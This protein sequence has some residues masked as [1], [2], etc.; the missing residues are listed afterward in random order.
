[1][2]RVLM[3]RFL[4]NLSCGKIAKRL[5]RTTNAAYSIIKRARIAIRECV[6]RKMRAAGESE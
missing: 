4:E 6:E 3:W 1:M 2:R 5:K